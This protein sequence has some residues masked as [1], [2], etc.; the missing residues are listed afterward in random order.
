LTARDEIE[1]TLSLVVENHAVFIGIYSVILHDD[2]FETP[3][4]RGTLIL[5]VLISSN[6]TTLFSAGDI[7]NL[8]GDF[9]PSSS[10]ALLINRQKN[11]LILHPD[12]L[13]SSTKVADTSACA[14]RALLQEIIRSSSNQSSP[15]LVYGNMLHELMQACLTEN[16]WSEEWRDEKIDGILKEVKELWGI[17]LG[18]EDAR[19]AMKEKS[20]GFGDFSNVYCRETPV[21]SPHPCARSVPTLTILLCN[22]DAGV[23]VDSHAIGSNQARL[24]ISQTCDV[25]EDIWSP[26]YGLK[27]KVDVSLMG[28]FTGTN[29]E[30]G[31]DKVLP[32]EI[33]TGKAGAGMEHRAQTM[34]YTLLMSDRYGS[35][36]S[37]SF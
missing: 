7:V 34:L 29:L 33:K 23:L 32:F 17:K 36:T 4:E 19:T 22:Q 35:C 3:V 16:K 1:Q 21:V 8:I 18:V 11:L 24:A 6:L 9:D 30:E 5:K 15:A 27:G 20:K 13:V 28:N 26:K 2:W 14:R 37:L 25:E 12:I 31:V 10:P